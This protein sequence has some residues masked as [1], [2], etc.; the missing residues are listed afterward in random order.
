MKV[1][2]WP[3]LFLPMLFLAP[4]ASAQE[5]SFN[6]L[7]GAN[8]PIELGDAGAGLSPKA[9]FVLGLD[10]WV[11]N[12]KGQ[13]WSAGASF[14]S[15]RRKGEATVNGQIIPQD[16]TL[17]YLNL[18]GAPLIWMLGKKERW[19]AEAGGFVNYLLRQETESSGNVTIN[20]E[21]FQRIYLGLSAGAGVRLGDENSSKLLIGL[22]NDLGLLSF[23]AGPRS[24]KF[25]AV[26]LFVGLG[27]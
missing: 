6:I 17:E 7:V 4:A 19:Y 25:N 15:F 13:V 11:K 2:I 14:N 8:Y 12:K 24:L 9:G 18:H 20:T 16:E 21:L 23:G 5:R 27:I 26:S 10:Y 3:K 1:S 22:R